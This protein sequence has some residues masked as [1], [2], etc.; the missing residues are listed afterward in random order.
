VDLTKDEA[1]TVDR[2]QGSPPVL[3]LVIAIRPLAIL[4]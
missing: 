2:G 4:E 1:L 3:D